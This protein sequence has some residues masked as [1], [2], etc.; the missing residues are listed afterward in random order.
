MRLTD[1][2]PQDW[3]QWLYPVLTFAIVAVLWALRHRSRAPL[4]A[5]LFFAGT[6]FPVLGF[7]NV[8][9]FVYSYVADHF[10]YLASLG[11]IVLIAS[12]I[13]VAIDRVFGSSVFQE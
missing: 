8:F 11:I 1:I 4:A 5:F 6:L 12:G 2:N 9:P 3:T 13:A 7:F 10:Q